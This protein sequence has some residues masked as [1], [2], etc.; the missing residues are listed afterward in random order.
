MGEPVTSIPAITPGIE[1]A[2][3]PSF[4]PD[5]LDLDYEGVREAAKRLGMGTFDEKSLMASHTLGTAMKKIGAIKL[6]RTLLLRAAEHAN[7]GIEQANQIIE[8]STDDE[9]KASVLTAKA[10]M[11]K[12]QVE[13]GD[14][15]IRSAEV[16]ASD[17]ADAKPVG[18]K[19]FVV[20][21]P[22]VVAQQAVVNAT[23]TTNI[24]QTS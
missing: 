19:P 17:D 4:A 21:Q 20:G 16:D 18:F 22:V 8:V 1:I 12:A 13:A 23:T 11:I 6:G 24:G 3:N 5:R 14:K 7:D 2:P 15:F 10:S 9:L